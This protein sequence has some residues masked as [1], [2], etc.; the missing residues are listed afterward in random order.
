MHAELDRV[1][2]LLEQACCSF[3]AWQTEQAHAQ[4]VEAG[5]ILQGLIAARARV[6]VS[7]ISELQEHRVLP[8]VPE[9]LAA[10]A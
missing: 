7:N 9:V 10:A 3:S 1:A 6:S 5:N 2:L 4:L 8:A